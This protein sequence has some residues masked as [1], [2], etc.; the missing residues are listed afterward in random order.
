MGDQGAQG[1]G[2]SGRRASFR[3]H[4]LVAAMGFLWRWHWRIAGILATLAI[5][6]FLIAVLGLRYWFL[7][8]VDQYRET[9]A[10]AISSAAGQRITIGRIAGSW[11]GL[12]PHLV[13]QDVELHDSR[14]RPALILGRVENTLSW[15]TLFL[16]KPRF[17]S[18]VIDHPT[19]TVRRDPQ[20][21]IFVA[22][23]PVNRAG[24]SGGFSDWILN[25]RQILVQGAVIQW[26][27][28][29]RQAPPLVLSHVDF[30]LRNRGGRHRFGV[31]ATPPAALASALDIRGDLRGR[32]FQDMGKWRGTL[33][34]R[35][36]YLDLGAWRQWISYPVDLSQGR[37]A[38][39]VWTD[40]D[41]LKP[42]GITADVRLEG[43][44]AKLAKDVQQLALNR[45][46]GRVAWRHLERGF[47]MKLSR[48]TLEGPPGKV[49][50]PLD[51]DLRLEKA[52][53]GRLADG[54]I[55]AKSLSLDPLLA[56]APY[57]PLDEVSRR[58]LARFSPRGGFSD[59]TLDWTG[60]W[61]EPQQYAIRGH[62]S[63]LGIN[64]VDKLPG[65]S[66]VTGNVDATEKGGALYLDARGTVI[67]LPR[68]F[69]NPLAL[70]TLTAQATWKMKQGAL[71][72]YLSNVSFANRDLAGNLYGTYH[73]VADS[74]GFL[75]LTGSLARADARNVNRYVPLVVGED[76]R[77]W[78]STAF[79][80]GQSD[81]VRLRLKGDLKHFPFSRGDGLFQ[82]KARITGAT[83]NY[84]A[85]WPKIDN[86]NADLLFEGPKM[87][88]NASQGSIMGV[89]LAKVR[90]E[91]PDFLAP[92]EMLDI[93]GEAQGPT[94]SFLAFISRSPVDE[95]IGS[96]TQGMDATGNGKLALSI[97]MP[98][99]HSKDTKLSGNFSFLN[100]RIT[101]GADLPAL[102]QVN[103]ALSFTDGGVQAKRIAANLLGGPVTIDAST[104]GS[105][106]KVSAQGR[107]TAE[108]L[109]QSFTSPVVQYLNGGTP[110]RGNL[111]IRG[112]E[113]DLVLDSTLQGLGSGLPAPLDKAPGAA[114]PLRIER[115]ADSARGDQIAV[116]YGDI[117]SGKFER[118]AKTSGL[119]VERGIIALGENAAE[120]TQ[121]GVWAVGSLPYLDLDR[122]RGILHQSRGPQEGGD[123]PLQ[124]SGLNLTV[125]TLDAFGRRFNGMHI[126]AW[127][128]GDGWQGDLSGKEVN[129]TVRWNPEGRG[130]VA[131][132]FR[133]LVIPD[134][135][136]AAR[137]PRSAADV[138]DYPSLDI[139]AD[140]LETKT[141]KLG[142]LDLYAVPQGAGW[143]IQRLALSAP[144]YELHMD[145]LWQAWL[146]QPRTDANITLDVQDIG[147]FLARY[148]YPDAVKRGSAILKGRLSWSGEPSDIDYPTL[149]GSATLEAKNGQFL[150]MDPG[151]GKLLGI[152]SLQALPRRI[153]LDFRDIFSQGFAFDRISGSM[154]IDQGV[155]STNDFKISGPAA[156]VLLTGETDLARETQRLTVRVT[157]LLGE[158]VSVAGALLG[159]P[160]V[161]LTTLLVQ[162][163]LQE[164]IDK[165]ASYEYGV[166][167]TWSGPKVVKLG[168]LQPEAVK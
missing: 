88:V 63:N 18:L 105:T 58:N 43:V 13:L 166:T 167:G 98:L 51:F 110:W 57:L 91:I 128:T 35:V 103:G 15:W 163:L 148:G 23:I 158:G 27:D 120:P 36:D 118:V 134:P 133:T 24:A 52:A 31:R 126:N 168:G 6:M 159:G 59:L 123:A 136:P 45:L 78:L 106:I 50:Q 70:D 125:G 87:E 53:D 2:V 9:I 89:S 150:K 155:L 137:V 62:F 96:F 12:R 108:G 34:A 81:D 20:G 40:V 5:A 121:S 115:K 119:Q 66:G 29:Q 1:K 33:Y 151:I 147:A 90:A 37:G 32:S 16:G 73:T 113:A 142:R 25:Q 72:L 68:V 54:A 22:G 11:T 4:P 165:L 138:Q 60:N 93:D 48:L 8:N 153:T 74:P 140:T 130:R 97:R 64:A 77:A 46:A 71:S 144:D 17:H 127:Q 109:R 76:A 145:G 104:Q 114:V 107:V 146:P 61:A 160:V 69:P 141:R 14:G 7:P 122:W 41:G 99:R 44:T 102:D 65:I 79:L 38:L 124:L 116:S 83:L 132:Q 157:P 55:A 139:Q 56:Y 162:K 67:D 149:S 117:L 49:E 26:L 84:A 152:L 86:V 154:R 112:K 94:A 75:D 47:E 80:D 101:A 143:K 28:E 129:G 21:V 111:T 100:N 42:A 19:L 161:G 95:M 131:A 39:R 10:S 156:T 85:G 82:V 30:L 164:P 3:S 135:A 92:E